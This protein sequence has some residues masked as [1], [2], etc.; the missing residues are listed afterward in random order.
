[1]IDTEARR[2]AEDY[3][4]DYGEFTDAQAD[5]LARAIQQSVDGWFD[6]YQHLIPRPKDE[7]EEADIPF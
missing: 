3:L 1:M 2:C 5:S 6:D 7:R 4:S